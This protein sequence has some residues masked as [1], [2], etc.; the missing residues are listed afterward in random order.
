MQAESIK[1]RVKRQL[2]FTGFTN[3]QG[4]REKCHATATDQEN[5]IP[6]DQQL[7]LENIKH[8]KT[9]LKQVE[10]LPTVKEIQETAGG[11]QCESVQEPG[12]IKKISN[13]KKVHIA[14]LADKYEPLIESLGESLN[15]ES[16]ADKKY[17]RKQKL[18]KC[19]K[20]FL[21]VLRTGW[22]YFVLG[23]QE[24]SNNYTMPYATSFTVIT[25]MR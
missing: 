22:K 11:H 17:K 2:P 7:T 1:S 14:F 19:R 12:Q 4:K 20:N 9:K 3:F 5:L 25:E 16:K 18:K 23:I 13:S 8:F 10:V 24:F 6:I 15:E 21:K